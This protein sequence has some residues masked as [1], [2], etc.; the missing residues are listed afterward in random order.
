[1]ALPI[2]IEELLSGRV[3]ETERLE[4]KDI[5]EEPHDDMY[6]IS[7]M[8]TKKISKNEALELI[9]K[10]N[11]KIEQGEAI[12]ISTISPEILYEKWHN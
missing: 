4:F 11:Q 12:Y 2:N 8:G 5:Y 1:M 7:P 9:R 6:E 10:Y 3:V